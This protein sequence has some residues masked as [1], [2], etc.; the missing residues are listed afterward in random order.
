[1]NYIKFLTV[2]FTLYS[3]Y[4]CPVYKIRIRTYS[5]KLAKL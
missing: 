4:F 5:V 3:A 2:V 1:M